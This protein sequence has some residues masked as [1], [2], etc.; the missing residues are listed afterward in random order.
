MDQALCALFSPNGAFGFANG[1]E[2]FAT[3]KIDVHGAGSLNWG[4]EANQI[5][6]QLWHEENPDVQGHDHP[7]IEATDEHQT[8]AERRVRLGL[9][10]AEVGRKNEIEVSDELAA[11]WSAFIEELR[12]NVVWREGLPGAT[13]CLSYDTIETFRR[14]G[15]TPGQRGGATMAIRRHS[16]TVSELLSG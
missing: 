1:V 5:A 16:A 15:A 14:G 6:H 8:L 12:A 11:S 4:A 3:E 2:W 10:L 7:E 13:L 9:L